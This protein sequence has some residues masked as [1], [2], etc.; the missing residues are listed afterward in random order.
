MV[1]HRETMQDLLGHT[2]GDVGVAPFGELDLDRHR[3]DIGFVLLELNRIHIARR[4]IS[5]KEIPHR[6]ETDA[7]KRE[8]LSALEY[9]L[10]RSRVSVRVFAFVNAGLRDTLSR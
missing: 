3:P 1:S 2:P 7:A 10:V 8:L 4:A 5:N 6:P 9:Q